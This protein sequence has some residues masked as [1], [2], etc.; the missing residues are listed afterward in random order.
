MFNISDKPLQHFRTLKELECQHSP[1]IQ[2]EGLCVALQSCENIEKVCIRNNKR[3]IDSD[4]ALIK[5]A[6]DILRSRK[7]NK[8]LEV[9]INKCIVRITPNKSLNDS[10][11]FLLFEIFDEEKNR[12]QSTS[13]E[14]TLLS[15]IHKYVA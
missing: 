12:C 5:F 10:V 2:N 14:E 4:I 1:Q 8:Y 13:D 7:N 3:S 9:C 15:F 11:A 6:I